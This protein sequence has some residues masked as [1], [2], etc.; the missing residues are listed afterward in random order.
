MTP[1]TV[2]ETKNVSLPVGTTLV[3]TETGG[4][5]T[6]WTG[7]SSFS[8]VLSA[9]DSTYKSGYAGIEVYQ[10]QS[11]AYNFRAGNVK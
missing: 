9:Y 2:L 5:L 3:L 4:K 6:I 1:E 11:T 8:R 7:T 10:G